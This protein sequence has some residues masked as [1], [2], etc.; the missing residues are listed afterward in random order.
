MQKIIDFAFTDIPQRNRKQLDDLRLEP[1]WLVV[2]KDETAVAVA[3]KVAAKKMKNVMVVGDDDKILGVVVKP[4]IDDQLLS[5]SQ[6]ITKELSEGILK[7]AQGKPLKPFDLPTRVR[8]QL[9]YCEKGR[10]FTSDYPC[11][12][13]P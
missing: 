11:R 2:K 9:F 4:Y 3:K 1:G 8:P 7:L 6:Q 12:D 5:T 13:H 10:H